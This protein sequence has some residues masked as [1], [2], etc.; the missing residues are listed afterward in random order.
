MSQEK[1]DRARRLRI[2]FAD[3]SLVA[4]DSISEFLRSRDDVELCGACMNGRDAIEKALRDQPDVVLLDLQM[5]ELS[6]LEA[7]QIF[8]S[9]MPET[10]VIMMS[11]HD[12]TEMRA[13]CLSGGADA[14]VSKAMLVR[15]F[16][17]AI[18]QALGAAGARLNQ[19]ARA[20]AAASAEHVTTTFQIPDFRGSIRNR[21]AGAMETK[22]EDP[23][24]ALPLDKPDPSPR[25]VF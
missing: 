10:A 3:D 22:G 7:A 13:A 24:L 2:L 11:V 4:R 17:A 20:R 6:G 25:R 19:Q 12:H 18:E 1:R 15:Q 14:F 5:P 16:D 23:G 9:C 21:P 8:R